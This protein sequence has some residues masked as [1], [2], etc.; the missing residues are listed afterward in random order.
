MTNILNGNVC[1]SGGAE[2]ADLQWGMTAGMA[3]HTVVHWSFAKHAAKSEAP[4]NE[5]VVLP[6][7]MLNQADPYCERAAKTLGRYF[8]SHK[9]WIANLLR[10]NWYQVRDAERVYA[11]ATID[12]KGIVSGGTAWAVQMFIDRFDGGPCE[13]YV[14]DQKDEC[15]YVWVGKAKL[16]WNHL[17]EGPPVPHGVWAGIGSRDLL[18]SGKAAIRA[19]MGYVAATK[20]AIPPPAA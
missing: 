17:P 15:W 9:P 14:F 19:L 20:V 18:A 10:R 2:G 13:A 7:E 11:V 5:V 1:L 4:V 3:G 16:G 12:N 6:Q 8:P